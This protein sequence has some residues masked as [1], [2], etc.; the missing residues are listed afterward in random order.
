[1]GSLVVG[2]ACLVLSGSD[3]GSL[4]GSLVVGFACLSGPDV[5]SLV[6]GFACLSEGSM[7]TRKSRLRLQY[8]TS[9]ARGL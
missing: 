7:N 6:V 8:S 5:G 3:V 2:F 4:V 1:M 9:Y